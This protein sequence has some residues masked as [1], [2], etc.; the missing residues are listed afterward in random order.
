M[1]RYCEHRY[2]CGS[3]DHL[4]NPSNA[5]LSSKCFATSGR[6]A[7]SLPGLEDL[8]EAF[9]SE[10]STQAEL[11]I[12][13]SR[14]VIG[15]AVTNLNLT[16]VA[17]PLFFPIIGDFMHRRFKTSADSPFASAPLGLGSFA[18][19]G[20]SINVTR[21][22]TG[23]AFRGE[24]FI[25]TVDSEGSFTLEQG[26][27]GISLTGEVGKLLTSDGIE[28]FVSDLSARSATQFEV[29]DNAWLKTVQNVRADLSVSEVGRQSGIIRINYQNVDA[30]IA[31][32]TV[33]EIAKIY[34]DQNIRR[35]SAEAENSLN[36]MREQIPFVQ[37]DLERA[38][39][40]FNKF[41]SE[42]QS[43]DVTV[44]NEAILNQLVE[45]DTRIQEVELQQVEL[46]RRFTANH[47]NVIAAEQ[48]YRRFYRSAHGS[49]VKLSHCRIPSK[50]Y[51]ACGAMWKLPVKFTNFFSTKHRKWRWREPVP[52]AMF[53]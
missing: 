22:N 38:E 2:L 23:D 45:L 52:L 28:L 18:W 13:K 9:G 37:R 53:V 46:N 35:L 27:F 50:N 41:A 16:T 19:G 3:C 44:E 30:D 5:R 21:F 1:G 11:E 12:L 34:V 29:S 47:P 48:Q 40:A 36:F 49:T 8:S 31:E 6:K 43:I 26:D 33:N 32:A 25:L 20:E 42:N 39:T 4:R 51:S 24:N 7:A 15:T 10:S 14:S 17:E